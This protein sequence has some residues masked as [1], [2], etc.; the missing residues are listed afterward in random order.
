MSATINKIKKENPWIGPTSPS[1]GPPSPFTRC[2][3]SPVPASSPN[4]NQVARHWI[5]PSATG[6]RSKGGNGRSAGRFGHPHRRV[7]AHNAG[8]GHPRSMRLR[9]CEREGEGWILLDLRE[10]SEGGTY[11]FRAGSMLPWPGRAPSPTR[12]L[13]GP[14]HFARVMCV[15]LAPARST[16]AAADGPEREM[17]VEEGV[18]PPCA[19]FCRKGEAPPAGSGGKDRDSGGSERQ[20][21]KMT[22]AEEGIG[23]G[24]GCDWERVRELGFLMISFIYRRW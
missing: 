12:P 10:E 3:C 18:L 22:C 16:S 17:G 21:E 7:D 19:V 24:C 23:L 15:C 1:T 11:L 4:R 13:V 8:S 9:I 5:G 6:S 2:R 14:P 20:G